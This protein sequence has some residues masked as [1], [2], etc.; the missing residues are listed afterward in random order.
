[1]KYFRSKKL[2]KLFPQKIILVM[3]VSVVISGCLPSVGNSSKL[4]KPEGEF[5]KG[6]IVAGFPSLPSYPKAKVIESY[7]S[8]QSFGASMVT[9]DNLAKVFEFYNGAFAPLGWTSTARKKSD[10]NI[11]YDVKNDKYAGQVI[12]NTAS[13]GKT[14]AITIAVSVK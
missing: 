8:S 4:P 13:D 11:V 3:L 14:T 9:G 12:I 1:M 6:A 7:G 5:K 10:T 2:L